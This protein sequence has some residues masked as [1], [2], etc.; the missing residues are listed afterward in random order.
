M[1]ASPGG[2]PLAQLLGRE[3]AALEVLLEERVV[4]LGERLDEPLAR[5]GDRV[6]QVGGHGPF[7]ERPGVALVDEGRPESRSTTPRNSPSLPIGSWRTAGFASERLQVLE[8]VVEARALAVEAG[9]EGDARQPRARRSQL[10]IFSSSTFASPPVGPRT[11]TAPVAAR[12][13]VPRVVQ[14]GRVAGRVDDVQLVLLPGGVV[15][16]RS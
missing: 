5:R 13:T 10:Q 12:E 14:E 8:R 2:A 6:G 3:L 16:R 15:E 1:R 4:G 7:L 9:H 11:T